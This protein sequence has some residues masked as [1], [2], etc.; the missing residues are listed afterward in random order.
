MKYLKSQFFD[1]FE[2]IDF[3]FAFQALHYQVEAYKGARSSNACAAVYHNGRVARTLLCLD[4]LNKGDQVIGIIGAAMIGPF[5]E[6]E[7]NHLL[8]EAVFF[9]YDC[10]LCAIVNLKA[11]LSL[12]CDGNTAHIIGKILMAFDLYGIKYI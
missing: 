12:D 7:V 5:F 10:E 1:C 6:K 9:V 11:F 3:R 8:F 4:F 2:Y